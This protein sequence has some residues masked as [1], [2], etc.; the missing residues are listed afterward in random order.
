MIVIC[1]G[2]YRAASTWQYNV[3]CHLVERFYSHLESMSTA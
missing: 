2:M 1:C 3:A